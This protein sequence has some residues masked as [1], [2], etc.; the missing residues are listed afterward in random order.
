M[1]GNV[2]EFKIQE[3]LKYILKFKAKQ[4]NSRSKGRNRSRGKTKKWRGPQSSNPNRRQAQ[5]AI[6]QVFLLVNNENHGVGDQIPTQSQIQAR[7]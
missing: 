2:C 1:S 4:S 6:K 5:R 3:L 7:T